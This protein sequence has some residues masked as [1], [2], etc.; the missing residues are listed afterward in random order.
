MSARV[1]KLEAHA[2]SLFAVAILGILSTT[3]AVLMRWWQRPAPMTMSDDWMSDL[4][5]SDSKNGSY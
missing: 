3:T 4:L 2:A 1:E 5:R